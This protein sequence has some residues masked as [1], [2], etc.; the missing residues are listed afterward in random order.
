MRSFLRDLFRPEIWPLCIPLFLATAIALVFIGFGFAAAPS[1][2]SELWLELGKAGIQ[3]L[4]IA[5]VGGMVAAAYRRLESRREERRRLDDYRIEILR[6][7]VES[8]NRIKAVRRTLRAYGFGSPKHGHALSAGQCSEYQTQMRSL[9]EAQLSL[10]KIGREVRAQPQVFESHGSDV[11]SLI[12]RAETYVHRVIED[13]ECF[14]LDITAGALATETMSKLGNLQN[15]LAPADI[16]E[17]EKEQREEVTFKKE[18]S[19]TVTEVERHIRWQLLAR[20][21]S[22][23]RA[24]QP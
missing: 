15:F 20:S 2:R 17:S 21:P 11:D 10:E 13:W 8:Y 9:L 6:G 23:A 3:L 7:L 1:E 5:V 18:V 24:S 12:H 22:R 4:V 16:G 19:L 14:G